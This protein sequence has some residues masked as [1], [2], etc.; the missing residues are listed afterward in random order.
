MDSF[1]CTFQLFTILHYALFR[2]FHLQFLILY[3]CSTCQFSLWTFF[4]IRWC[5]YIYF[6]VYINDFKFLP[7]FTPCQEAWISMSRGSIVIAVY[8]PF[9]YCIYI[10]HFFRLNFIYNDISV[11]NLFILNNSLQFVN[12]SFCKYVKENNYKN[13]QKIYTWENKIREIFQC[14]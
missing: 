3:Q 9:L 5:M 7:C 13:I 1:S 14:K 10:F 8:A 6:I 11:H 2:V 12:N 4:D